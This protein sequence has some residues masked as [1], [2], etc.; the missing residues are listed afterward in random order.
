MSSIL[1]MSGAASLALHTAVILAANPNKLIST[2]D[3]ASLLR[4]SEA[5]LS[6]VLQQ[7]EK[8]NIVTSIRGPKGGFRLAKPGDEITLLDVYESIE[9]RLSL[10]SCLLT[11]NICD[12]R[13]I[14]GKMINDLNTRFKDYLSKTKLDDVSGFY[15]QL[16]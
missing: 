14:M 11:E 13:C 8:T 10:N 12:G 3:I 7:L 2:K 9:G 5:H 1:K 6:K 16:S 15:K 4:A